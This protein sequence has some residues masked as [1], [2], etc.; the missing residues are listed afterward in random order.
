MSPLVRV[1][2][3]LGLILFGFL[4][5]WKTKI[6]VGMFGRND[7]AER[8]MGVGQTK[9]FYKFIGTFIIMFGI[10]LVTDLLDIILGDFIRGLF[11]G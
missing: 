5:V 8:V 6:M 7:W 1:L 11:G 9:T 2:L 10:I 4:A 3:G